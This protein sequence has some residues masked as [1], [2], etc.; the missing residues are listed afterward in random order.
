[1]LA[2]TR[3]TTVRGN[4]YVL[5]SCRV[6]LSIATSTS[7]FGGLSVPRT[8][9]R[10]LI[11]LPSSALSRPVA[12]VVSA[13]RGGADGDEREQQHPEAARGAEPHQPVALLF[14]LHG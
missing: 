7:C 14:T 5:T 11:V 4:G 10:A 8:E 2:I 3:P 6:L 12:Y 9:N 13:D 1:M